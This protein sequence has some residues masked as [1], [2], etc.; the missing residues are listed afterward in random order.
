MFYTVYILYSYK[1]HKLYVGCTSD[2]DKRLER[3][4]AGNVI[5]T[6]NRRPL[7]LIHQESFENKTTA[8]NRERFLKSLWASREKRGLL[9]K[10]LEHI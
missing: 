6:R 2:L 4:N 5:A 7:V 3:H 1:D 9:Q 10:Y 8:F